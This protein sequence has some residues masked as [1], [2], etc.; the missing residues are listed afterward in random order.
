MDRKLTIR[1]YDQ[2]YRASVV[3]LLEHL[4]G[5]DA[6]YRQS[7]FHWKYEINPLSKES[8]G[9]VA[10]YGDRVVGFRG[11]FPMRWRV[12]QEKEFGLL[13]LADTIIDPDYRGKGIFLNSTRAIFQLYKHSDYRGVVNLSSSAPPL[14][15][16]LKL[17]W[18]PIF[19]K[20]YY[21]SFSWFPGRLLLRFLPGL[22]NEAAGLNESEQLTDSFICTQLGVQ[23]SFTGFRLSENDE[24][25]RWRY[26]RPGTQ[27]RYFSLV[28]GAKQAYAVG[29]TP[30]KGKLYLL[31]YEANSDSQLKAL[32]QSI[33]YRYPESTINAWNSGSQRLK[34]IFG[35][36]SFSTGTLNHY[37]ET[38]FRD[39][40]PILIRPLPEQIA[41]EDWSWD[42]RDILDHRN[43]RF[44]E[45][46]SDGA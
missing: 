43:W 11:L 20:T 32:L 23:H 24:Y 42:G 16:Y 34:R 3:K 4:W 25:L 9:I 7:Y 45:I 36:C 18:K 44:R 10:V 29:V 41:E 13:A 14:K 31:D 37:I 6:D 15:G 21:R 33:C 5:G 1:R 17:G 38:H 35:R 22:R 12:N 46:Y 26:S 27:Y 30:V 8:E 19:P 2:Q 40:S 39:A 28:K